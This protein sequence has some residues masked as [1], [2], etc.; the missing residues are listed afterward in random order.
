MSTAPHYHIDV[1]AFHRDPYPDLARLRA[2]MP[3]AYVPELGATIFTKR[4][5]IFTNEKIIEVFSS[6]QPGGLMTVLMGENLM[7]KDGA[8]HQ[9][10]RKA[11]FPT[12]SPRTVKGDWALARAW[13]FRALKGAP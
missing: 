7:R 10:E 11:I 3:I 9:A 6:H 1:A 13:L 5:A 8:A 12:I 4:D 2:E